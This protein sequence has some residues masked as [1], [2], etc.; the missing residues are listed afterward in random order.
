MLQTRELDPWAEAID[1][2]PLAGDARARLRAAIGYAVLAPSSHNSQ[3][4]LFQISGNTLELRADRTRGLP[5]SD[6]DDRELTMAC[7]AA[8]FNLRVTL[9]YFGE[10]FE[11]D[12]LPDPADADLMARIRIT[13]RGEAGV[14]D[15]SLFRAIPRRHT[16]RQPFE[17]GAV[18]EQ[19][20]AR[21]RAGAEAE[22]A[23]LQTLTG[24]ADRVALAEIIAEAD[25]QQMAD[26]HFRRELAAW[27]HANRSASRDGM[28][29]YAH[30]VGDLAS[31][32]APVVIRS[33]DLGRGAAA[34]D[35]QLALGSPVL[36]VLWTESESPRDW[37]KAGQA[38]EHALLRLT[39]DG[40]SVSYL[41][42]AIEVP[43]LRD[44]IGR[45]LNREGWPQ[46]ILRLGFG[47]VVRPTQRRKVEDVLVTM[48]RV[49]AP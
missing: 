3:P 31:S 19:L 25:R 42:Q 48:E 13:G 37:L 9:D 26:R 43:E 2:Y 38:L 41:N 27:L 34:R 11:I 24:E 33:F 36:A 4:W 6:P 1:S 21:A 49:D 44:G 28:P 29:G 16:N 32:L 45:L 7:G 35:R 10:Q 15:A 12:T 39:T 8:L 30:G 20:L 14:K 22:G 40:V 18:P 47:P 5:V 17:P 23:W 46:L